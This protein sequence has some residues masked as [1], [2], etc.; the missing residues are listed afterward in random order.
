MP[1]SIFSFIKNRRVLLLTHAGADVDAISSCASIYFAFRDKAKIT[2]AVPEHI[3]LN[4]KALAKNLGIPYK[5]NPAE[6]SD[7]DFLIILDLNS[8]SMLGYLKD[9]VKGFNKPIALIDHHTKSGDKIAS[10]EFTIIREGAVSTTELIYELFKKEK[11]NLTPKI[12]KCI[13]AGIATDSAN[14]LVADRKTFRIMAEV[15]HS[16]GMGYAELLSLSRIKV[17]ISKKIAVLKAAK[18]SKI[19]SAFNKIIVTADVGA[20]EADAASTLV[21]LGAD[22]AFAAD[23]EEGKILVSA[24]ADNQFIKETGFSLPRDIFSKLEKEFNGSGGGHSAAAGFNGRGKGT[25]RILNRSIHLSYDFLKNRFKN[26]KPGLKK[27]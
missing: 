25:E 6:I 22:I 9:K 26:K 19:Y 15:L 16:S 8:F 1:P 18:R 3:N 7:F 12:S 20:Y 21:K 5:M 17:D 10:P 24:R 27:Y 4:A 2:I 23:E 13:A 11:I 14:F